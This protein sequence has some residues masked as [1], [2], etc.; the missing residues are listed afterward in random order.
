ME[1][2]CNTLFKKIEEMNNEIKKLKQK[3][4]LTNRDNKKANWELEK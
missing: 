3:E 1:H 2:K 4:E